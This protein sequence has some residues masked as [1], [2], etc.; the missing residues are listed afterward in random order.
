MIGITFQVSA[1]ILPRRPR[2]VIWE[3]VDEYGNISFRKERA[4]LN[5]FIA[6][7]HAEG[8]AT[9]YIIAYAGRVSCAGEAQSRANRVRNYLTH[10][11][12]IGPKRIKII[13]AGYH[14]EWLIELYVAPPNAPP[15]TKAIFS[16]YDGHLRPDQ[17]SI[18]A[19]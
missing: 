14:E 9:A 17:V 19:N 3:K 4:R 8:D 2:D 15:L 1:E 12:G 7:L 5:Q 16:D 11:G 10:K 6:R 13:N 18:L